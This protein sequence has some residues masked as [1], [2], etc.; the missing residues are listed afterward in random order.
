MDFNQAYR[1]LKKIPC[2][3]VA[4]AV[5]TLAILPTI[6]TI[7][8]LRKNKDAATICCTNPDLN[9]QRCPV[10][11]IGACIHSVLLFTS[12]D[13]AVNSRGAGLAGTGF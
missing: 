9:S 1:I 11:S 12:V 5:L 2:L 8:P 4:Y 7:I 3:V 13:Y 10:C 6:S